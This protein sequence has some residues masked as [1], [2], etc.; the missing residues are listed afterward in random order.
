MREV[1]YALVVL[2]AL[3]FVLASPFV[4]DGAELYRPRVKP[5][6]C[7]V[8]ECDMVSTP[9]PQVV[10]EREAWCR[11]GPKQRGAVGFTVDDD[12]NVYLNVRGSTRDELQLMGRRPICVGD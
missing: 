6:R 10:P 9:C 1:L 12:G 5:A 2:V 3:A 11:P 8:Y 7:F 4:A